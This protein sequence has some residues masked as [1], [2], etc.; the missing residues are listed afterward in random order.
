MKAQSPIHKNA[1]IPK[2]VD[3]NGLFDIGVDDAIWD[4]PGLDGDVEET[5]PAWLADEK[6]REGI[7]AMLM[8][9]WG[10]EE[11]SRLNIEMQALFASLTEQYLA[12][13]KAVAKWTDAVLLFEIRHKGKALQSTTSTPW[14]LLSSLPIHPGLQQ[15]S[16]VKVDRDTEQTIP[17]EAEYPTLMESENT[18]VDLEELDQDR[19]HTG[20]DV[21][22][23][24]ELEDVVMQELE[25]GDTYNRVDLGDSEDW[26][27]SI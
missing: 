13:E 17:L 6:T 27:D 5:P 18:T 9:D 20:Q 7:K 26:I 2:P 15:P 3:I 23:E 14:Q 25:W 22:D 11:I 24:E 8:Y 16:F 21:E 10:K 1:V 19:W 12:I 4:N